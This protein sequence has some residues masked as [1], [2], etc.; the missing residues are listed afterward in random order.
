MGRIGKLEYPA[1]SLE[2]AVNDARGIEKKPFEGKVND[3]NDLADSWGHKNPK[4]GSF[5]E[6]IISLIR[7]GLAERLN[8][9]L[10]LTRLA[11]DILH[12]E[13]DLVSQ[14]AKEGAFNKIELFQ[15]LRKVVGDKPKTDNFW[16]VLKQITN[17][18]K[19]IALKQAE[20]I[21]K[22]YL[23]SVKYITLAE[24]PGQPTLVE[25]IGRREIEVPEP[26][27]M[28]IA[29]EIGEYRAGNIYVRSPKNKE[30]IDEI[31]D[32]L[33]M[34]EKRLKTETPRIKRKEGK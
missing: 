30:A 9:G 32:I 25:G 34:W 29:P 1:K 8:G 28:P 15:E 4:S 20:S 27:K 13:N 7:Y 14:K 5:K 33:N 21:R 19:S 18:D 24:K 12:P 10:R 2:K 22:V 16:I 6:R 17:V 11:M 31:R 23:E 26:M 3:T